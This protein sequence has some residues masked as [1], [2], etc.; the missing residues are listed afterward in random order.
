MTEPVIGVLT[1]DIKS[2]SRARF[3]EEAPHSA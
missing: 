1:D 2:Y 3:G